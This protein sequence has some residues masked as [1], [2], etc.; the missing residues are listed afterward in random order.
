MDILKCTSLVFFLLLGCKKNTY[1]NDN[2]SFNTIIMTQWNS[3]ACPKKIMYE[4]YVKNS[5]FKTKIK[6]DSVFDRSDCENDNKSYNQK[7]FVPYILGT[8]QRF[9]LGS[10]NYDIR[11]VFDD[12]LEFKITSIKNK[13]D[14]IP[15]YPRGHFIVINNIS[16]LI[17]NGH[18]LENSDS[19]SNMKISTKL[20]NI[21]TNN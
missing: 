10:I 13:I 8:D 21:I 2:N 18:K 14:T 19:P 6:T 1:T 9:I 12:S 20:G 11:L 3:P 7:T 16:S 15:D 4:R 5:N 17:V